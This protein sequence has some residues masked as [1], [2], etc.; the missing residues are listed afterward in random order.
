[1]RFSDYNDVEF[2]PR[3]ANVLDF[4]GAGFILLKVSHVIEWSWLWV[5]APLWIQHAVRAISWILLRIAS[6]MEARR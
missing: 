6:R 3:V 4:L 1:M 5:V 2:T